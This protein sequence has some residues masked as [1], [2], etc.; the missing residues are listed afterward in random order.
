MK[1]GLFLFLIIVLV[2]LISASAY[3][4]DT[5][6]HAIISRFGEVQKI[7]VNEAGYETV[8]DTVNSDV[9]SKW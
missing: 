5:R 6:E 4:V 3:T 2:M 1:K 8:L 7:V 9:L